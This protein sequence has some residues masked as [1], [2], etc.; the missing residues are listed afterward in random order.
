MEP[1]GSLEDAHRRM[2]GGRPCWVAGGGRGELLQVRSW[3]VVS[4]SAKL[5]GGGGGQGRI[6]PGKA[7]PRCWFLL[8]SIKRAPG[9]PRSIEKNK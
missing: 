2:I 6:R 8:L 7:T 5:G 1:P 9:A 3:V 4:H